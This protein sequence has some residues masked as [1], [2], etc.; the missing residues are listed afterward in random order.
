MTA[1][2]AW[3]DR[4]DFCLVAD[5]LTASAEGE[6][7]A[8]HEQKTLRINSNAAMGAAIS[9]WHFWLLVA[10]V[11][12]L[13]VPGTFPKSDGV[14]SCNDAFLSASKADPGGP[15]VGVRPEPEV[16]HSCGS[17]RTCSR[18]VGSRLAHAQRN[19]WTQETIDG[20]ETQSG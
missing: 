2:L 14:G 13:T 18:P 17:C 1:I 16:F 8:E 20:L 3:I 10:H 6:V 12:G 5:G 19:R 11:M 7:A 15:V 4:G 9:S